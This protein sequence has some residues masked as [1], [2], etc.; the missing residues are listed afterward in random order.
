MYGEE[1]EIMEYNKFKRK[2][3]CGRSRGGSGGYTIILV[4]ENI[5][6]DQNLVRNSW[7]LVDCHE[8]DPIF[9]FDRHGS[10]CNLSGICTCTQVF[11]YH[12]KVLSTPLE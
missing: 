10:F 8:G 7:Q 9:L 4:I 3:G 6:Y 2:V 1:V 11:V 12:D 5:I